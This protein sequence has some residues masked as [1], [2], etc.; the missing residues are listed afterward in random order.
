MNNKNCISCKYNMGIVLIITVSP[1]SA[2]ISDNY[3]VL[4]DPWCNECSI[5]RIGMY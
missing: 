3:P 1:V 4:C 5:G 2:Y